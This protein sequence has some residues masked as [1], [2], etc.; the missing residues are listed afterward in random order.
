M[1]TRGEIEA[2]LRVVCSHLLQDQAHEAAKRTLRGM[3]VALC[4]VLDREEGTA[5]QL[6]VDGFKVVSKDMVAQAQ[7]AL[8]ERQRVLSQGDQDHS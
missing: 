4:W 5:M 1:K 6:L 3:S 7:Q 8:E 2:G